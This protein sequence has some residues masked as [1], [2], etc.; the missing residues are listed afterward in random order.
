[1]TGYAAAAGIGLINSLGNLGGFLAPNMR[2]YFDDHWGKPNG[3]YSLAL[4]AVLAAI[5][6]GSTALFRKAN[7]IE[8]GHIEG[9][10]PAANYD[11]WAP[12]L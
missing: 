10:D 1:M 5:L 12:T 4:G 11:E 7:Q 2:A 6:F 3:L 9:V 8:A